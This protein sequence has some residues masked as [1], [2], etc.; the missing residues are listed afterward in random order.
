MIDADGSTQPQ[1]IP[2]FVEALMSGADMAKGSRFC[3]GGG[4]DHIAWTRGAGNAALNTIANAIHGMSCSVL[5]YGCMAFWTDVA[6]RLGPPHV[7]EPAPRK[8]G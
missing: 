1:E 5:C 8:A 3:E 2:R 4:S 7:L 6:P